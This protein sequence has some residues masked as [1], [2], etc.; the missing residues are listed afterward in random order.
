MKSGKIYVDGIERRIKDP[1]EAIKLGFAFVSE[2][3]RLEGLIIDH[4]VQKNLSIVGLNKLKRFLDYLD[5]KT[6]ARIC[7]ANIS[8]FR[9]AT[10]RLSKPVKYLSGGNQQKVVIAK[11]LNVNPKVLILDEPTRG[12]DVGAKKEIYSILSD[13]TKRGIAVFIISSEQN[14]VMGLCDRVLVIRKGELVDE[15]TSEFLTKERLLS[16]SMGGAKSVRSK[17]E[18]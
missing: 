4:S 7:K 18:N 16:A 6:E 14:E 8:D 1:S 17:Q 15:I 13:L 12:V 5:V 10:D 2:D 3:R 11:W 9:I